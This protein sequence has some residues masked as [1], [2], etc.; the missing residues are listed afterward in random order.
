MRV[1]V[2]GA[3]IVGMSTAYWL[4]RHGLRVTV[5]EQRS[6]PAQEASF[7]TAGLVAPPFNW[8]TTTA[9]NL[10]RHWFKDSFKQDGPVRIRPGFDAQQWRW[11]REWRKQS[12]SSQAQA[13]RLAS[14]SLS[15]YSASLLQQQLDDHAFDIEWR[16]GVLEL[17]DA[18]IPQALL[19]HK[20]DLLDKLGLPHQWLNTEA[21][22]HHDPALHWA[23]EREAPLAGA[24]YYPQAGSGNCPLH[25]RLLAS[26][27]EAR[28]VEFV[29]GRQAEPITSGTQHI[30][31]V[32]LED[33]SLMSAEAVVMATASLSET[34]LKL[35]GNSVPI[36]EINGY[37]A[38][39][40]LHVEGASPQ[41]AWALFEQPI[42]MTPFGNRVRIAGTLGIHTPDKNMSQPALRLLSEFAMRWLP[43]QFQASQF[44]WWKG[45]YPMSPDGL[46][47]LGALGPRGLYLNVGHGQYGWTQSTGSGKI[48]ADL[49]AGQETDIDPS[50]Y[51]PERPHPPAR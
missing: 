6:G 4:N 50:P 36:L 46:P 32:V 11:L 43:G 24:L 33:G 9:R 18:S 22:I 25:A 37:A 34:V 45:V 39:V 3:G 20:R 12:L 42:S 1:I 30:T 41:Q 14:R 47:L 5:I 10:L 44:H 49:I 7:G 17:V 51:Q 29:Y 8:P 21:A 23:V 38:N 48:V 19:E 15:R 16:Q 13:N 31:G 27:L 28:G 35:S 40:P 26:H 2:I